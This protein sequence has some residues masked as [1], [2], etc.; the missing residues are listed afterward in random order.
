[1]NFTTNMRMWTMKSSICY[2]ELVFPRTHP[3][4]TY[5]KELQYS[6]SDRAVIMMVVSGATAIVIAKILFYLYTSEIY[7][8][9]EFREIYAFARGYL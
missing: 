6:N 3:T 8:S 2:V 5:L 4:R 7:Y 9:S 1:M